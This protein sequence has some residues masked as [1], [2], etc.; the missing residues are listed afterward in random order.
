MLLMNRSNQ[1]LSALW[2]PGKVME[3]GVLPTRNRGKKFSVLSNRTGSFSVSKPGESA[4][5]QSIE[6]GE[7]YEGKRRIIF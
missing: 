3:T 6:L 5:I 1:V 2:N 7:N 4:V